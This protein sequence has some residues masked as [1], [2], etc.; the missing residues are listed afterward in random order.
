MWHVLLGDI[1]AGLSVLFDHIA[2]SRLILLVCQLLGR[3]VG[4]LLLLR[5]DHFFDGESRDVVDLLLRVKQPFL[6]HLDALP[7]RLNQW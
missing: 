2:R 7:R 5:R 6:L 4:S 3:S 1:F